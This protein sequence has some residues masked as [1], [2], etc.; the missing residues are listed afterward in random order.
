MVRY[1]AAQQTPEQV[2]AWAAAATDELQARFAPPD[3]EDD[4]VG[5][6]VD[7]SLTPTTALEPVAVIRHDITGI[8]KVASVMPVKMVD[9]DTRIATIWLDGTPTPAPN[10]PEDLVNDPRL[11]DGHLLP[12]RARLDNETELVLWEGPREGFVIQCGARG[13]AQRMPHTRQDPN[14][15]MVRECANCAYRWGLHR[16]DRC[17]RGT[18]IPGRRFY[19][20][21]FAVGYN[22]DG[23]YIYGGDDLY[24][25]EYSIDGQ[26]LADTE[27]QR[28]MDAM[29]TMMVEAN[30]APEAPEPLVPAGDLVTEALGD[31]VEAGLVRRNGLADD[32]NTQYILNGDVVDNFTLAGDR[33]AAGVVLT[34]D[35]IEAALRWPRPA[36]RTYTPA[37]P[38]I[39]D[40]RVEW[41]MVG[42]TVTGATIMDDVEVAEEDVDYDE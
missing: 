21:T 41:R 7:I 8:F 10:E 12:R 40:V 6:A 25:L 18:G 29:R 34:R 24:D 20:R 28:F 30:P 5:G 3:E 15:E 27:K 31:L 1:D 4:E 13:I 14:V 32:P 11:H 2:M 22:N 36:F 19:D 42:Q 16:G 33:D 35:D 39:G 26:R 38:T 23:R 9:E 17:P 37:L